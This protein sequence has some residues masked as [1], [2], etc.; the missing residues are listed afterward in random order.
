MLL[1]AS[2][3]R[4]PRRRISLHQGIFSFRPRSLSDF[5]ILDRDLQEFPWAG[6]REIGGPEQEKF[7]AEQR[8]AQRITVPLRVLPGTQ[9]A[10]RLWQFFGVQAGGAAMRMTGPRMGADPERLVLDRSRRSAICFRRRRT[11]RPDPPVTQRSYDL[12]KVASGNLE[13]VCFLR[14]ARRVVAWPGR[15]QPQG[16][17]AHDRRVP[18]AT[19]PSLTICG[20]D[21]A[22]HAQAHRYRAG[23]FQGEALA[24]RSADPLDAA[25]FRDACAHLPC[26]RLGRPGGHCIPQ[27]IRAQPHAK[28]HGIEHG[29]YFLAASWSELLPAFDRT[30]RLC[31]ECPSRLT[32]SLPLGRQYL[33]AS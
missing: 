20:G 17:E 10:M 1:P 31:D 25:V 18:S 12:C 6:N 27:Q 26:R 2:R 28:W 15:K 19:S 33:D 24:H 3:Y 32:N 4:I 9:Y 14:V 22:G 5:S 7:A 23:K 11:A 16:G 13:V 30:R 21:P 8:I 29:P